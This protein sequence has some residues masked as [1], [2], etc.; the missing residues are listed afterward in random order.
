MHSYLVGCVAPRRASHAFS[1]VPDSMLCFACP[2]QQF[3]RTVFKCCQ[4]VRPF[5][6]V[7]TEKGLGRM[8]NF[9]HWSK[10]TFDIECSCDKSC[11]SKCDAQ[12]K[13]EECKEEV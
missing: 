7:S 6:T 2:V 3:S 9:G 10:A 4:N 13:D 12:V 8:L 5:H 11:K 1:I